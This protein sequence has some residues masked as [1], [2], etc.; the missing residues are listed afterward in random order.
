VK[1][2]TVTKH[3]KPRVDKKEKRCMFSL[4]EQPL[5][6]LKQ[7]VSEDPDGTSVFLFF[8]PSDVE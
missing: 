1:E 2:Q 8:F 5:F 7:T 3:L 4:K 6:R